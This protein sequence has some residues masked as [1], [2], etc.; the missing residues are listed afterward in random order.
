MLVYDM[1]FILMYIHTHTHGEPKPPPARLNAN[2]VSQRI[3]Y[4][5]QWTLFNANRLAG[6]TINFVLIMIIVVSASVFSRGI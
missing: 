3:V 4:R 1:H 5:R 2:F 6:A